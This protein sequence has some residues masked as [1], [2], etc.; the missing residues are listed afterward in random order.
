VVHVGDRHDLDVEPARLA[1]LRAVHL[2]R[3]GQG[4]TEDPF[5]I[6]S[7]RDLA[8]LLPSL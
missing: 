8:G 4:P 6:T 2:D 3:H 7:L 5:R 1:G